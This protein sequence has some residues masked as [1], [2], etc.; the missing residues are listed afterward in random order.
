MS[1]I[2][3][4]IFYGWV[5]VI[6]LF[7]VYAVIMG[8]NISFGVFFNS[9]EN[10]F[11]LTRAATSSVLSFRMISGA[12]IAFLGGWAI[13]RYGPRL[14]VLFMGVFTSLGLILTSQTNSTWQLFVTLGLL[15]S[16]GGGA[17]YVT[18]MATSM[19][20]FE[21]RRG[22]AVG[23]VGAGGGMGQITFAPFAAYLIQA[24]DWR[25][26]YLAMGILA[27]LVL[28]P[29]S[30]LIKKDPRAIGTVPDGEESGRV[31]NGASE[32]LHT[33][34]GSLHALFSMPRAFRTR[35]FYLILSLWF[36]TAFS[37]FLIQTHIVP[38]ALDLGF[39]PVQ[40]ALILSL[41]GIAVM[42]GMLFIGVA[43]D[44]IDRKKVAI[45]N[46][47]FQIGAILLLFMGGGLRN[48]YLFA[49]IYG[50]A[51]GGVSSAT[52]ALIGDIFGVSNVGKLMGILSVGWAIGAGTGPLIG[53]LI[54][55]ISSSY[56]GAFLFTAAIL[57]TRPLLLI[58]LR[59]DTHKPAFN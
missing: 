31:F 12:A 45:T 48:L 23:I 47:L 42:I 21:K 29:I 52:T 28:V 7:F 35:N 55:D 36:T 8:A 22:A 58:L 27:G 38:H 13:D 37:L 25:T 15:L 53:G 6:A 5:V 33:E 43:S 44:R 20:W 10:E 4:K 51:Q 14:I 57:G 30:W 1:L 50:L 11:S 2:Q 34:Q 49:I 46:S 26:A 56:N 9:L 39:S 54:F 24:F 3:K 41:F 19:R 17:S 18:V 59:H 40:S 32:S 16:I